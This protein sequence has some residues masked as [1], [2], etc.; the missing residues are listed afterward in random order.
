[1]AVTSGAF[2][3]STCAYD[4]AIEAEH[5]SVE[6][7]DFSFWFLSCAD[8]CTHD[9]SK[10]DSGG[11]SQNYASAAVIGYLSLLSAAMPGVLSRGVGF[12]GAVRMSFA[13]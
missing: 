13:S 10:S 8:E 4:L 3:A 12:Y 6:R 1:M 2:V 11:A 9:S 7:N 5:R